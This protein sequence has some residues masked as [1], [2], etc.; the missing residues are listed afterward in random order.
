M[1]VQAKKVTEIL[2]TPDQVLALAPDAGSVKRGRAL[3]SVSV[4]PVLGQCDDGKATPTDYLAL[5]GECQGSGKRPYRSSVD[6]GAGLAG[7]APAFY[8]SCPSRKF[9]CK[10]VL[11]LLLLWVRQ[12]GFSPSA[13]PEWVVQWL[14]K[15]AETAA[16]KKE[17]QAPKEESEQAREKKA[18]QAQKRIERREKKVA[19]GLA[20]LDQWLQDI[21]CRGLADLPNMPYS[22]WDQAAARLIDAQAPGLAGRVRAMASIPHSGQGW[23]ERLL[24]A[25]GQLYLL[26]KGYAQLSQLSPAMQAE[27][28]SQ[29][30][31]SL[32]KET[33]LQR[34]DKQTLEQPLEGEAPVVAVTDTWQVLSREI[35]EEASLKT[36]RLWLWGAKSGRAGLVLSFAHGRRQPL[37]VSLVPGSGFVGRLIFYP[38]TGQ[39][40][41]GFRAL[42]A[43]RGEAVSEKQ[44]VEA[45]S[46]LVF[47]A[48][49]AHIDKAIAHYAHSLR[50]NPWQFQVPFVLRDML[51]CYGNQQWWL[52]DDS[53]RQLPIANKFSQGWELLA[54][55]GGRRL[56]VFG[57]W[58]GETLLPLSVWSDRKF[59]PLEN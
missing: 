18:Q 56:S 54:M 11:G 22:F 2:W 31:F 38:G 47:T 57:E 59:M 29:I 5:W 7:E 50:Q 33:L 23:P 44:A 6:F 42:V 49:F 41:A 43:E 15:R 8:C 24:K 51:L 13:P 53:H 16:K 58:S 19:E 26:V 35:T 9:P 37:D 25:L 28:R 14:Q 52:E 27:I 21:M 4:W 45:R 10:H 48:G 46:Q 12:G 34:A 30:G 55:S 36:Q 32:T 39:R 3:A 17:Q 40:N 20:D 1:T